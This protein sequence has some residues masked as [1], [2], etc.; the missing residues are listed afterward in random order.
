MVS[1]HSSHEPSQ[2]YVPT[3]PQTIVDDRLRGRVAGF[4][5]LAFLGVAP[6]GHMAAGAV[7]GAV[8]AQNAF[9]LNGLACVA[10]GLVFMRA[11]PRLSAAI[12]PIY[13]NLGI[14]SDE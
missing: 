3:A 8:G 4:Y 6:L 2:P 14:P 7:A 13:R 5:T 9:L 10:G 12:R 1:R 11:L